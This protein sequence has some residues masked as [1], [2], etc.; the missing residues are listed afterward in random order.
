MHWFGRRLD[1][2]A[3]NKFLIIALILA[4][5]GEALANA[6]LPRVIG[7]APELCSIA[8]AVLLVIHASQ[9]GIP[10]LHVA[11]VVILSLLA[12]HIMLGI[13]ANQVQVGTVIVGARIYLRAIPFFL[14]AIIAPP[15]AKQLTA[16]I[17]TTVILGLIQL[18]LAIN[19]RLATMARDTDHAKYLT[20]GDW[21]VGTFMN[22]AMLS[23]FCI[24]VAALVFA[25]LLRKAVHWRIAVPVLIILLVP[26]MINETKATIFLIPICFVGIALMNPSG[27]KRRST[28]V[29]LVTVALFTAVFIPTYD[30][31]MKPRWGYGIIDFFTMEGRVENYLDKG[32]EVGTTGKVG[33]IDAFKLPVK[34]LKNDPS[35]LMLGLGLGNVTES[36]FGDQYA[37]AYF[38][39]YGNLLGP[40]VSRLLWEIGI[41]GV[42]LVFA[43]IFL[44]FKTALSVRHRDGPAGVLAQAWIGVLPVFVIGMF[45][46]E[47]MFSPGLSL[48]FWYLSGVIVAYGATDQLPATEPEHAKPAAGPQSAHPVP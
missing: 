13:I 37:G 5:T 33:R 2:L 23:I 15:K 30:Y 44:I 34:T 21:T 42:V 32:G 39:R 9:R 47:I 18:P 1:N 14:L 31:F 41:L 24:S 3:V 25:A 7:Y 27:A 26:T 17:I 46:K 8:A 28:V 6:G 4:V 45:Y 22:S 20:T 40:T 48:F 16:L 43:L 19:Q 36:V 29:A 11:F 12:M 35:A 38:R 10:Q